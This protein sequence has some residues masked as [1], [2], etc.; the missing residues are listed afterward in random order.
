[1]WQNFL[2][3]SGIEPTLVA[4]GTFDA[5]TEG[6]TKRWQVAAGLK[7][8]G[9]VGPQSFSR[10]M[11]VGFNPLHDD[12]ADENGQNWPVQP[13]DIK[14]LISNESREALFGKFAYKPTGDVGEI[15]ITDK[16]EGQNI[17]KCHIPFNGG[18]DVRMNKK[19]IPQ[20]LALWKAWSDASLLNRVLTWDGGFVPR[21]VR[22]SRTNLSNHSW[23]TAFDIN[24]E[25]N[26]LGKQGALKGEKGCIR[27]LMVIAPQFGFFNGGWFKSRPDFM[28]F[29]VF[30]II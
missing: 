21:F 28:H 25:W 7:G 18:K 30:K 20:F 16:W 22:G 11:M 9:V 8:D 24:A 27:E 19:I 1:M 5:L 6:A 3:G 2:V 10:A 23:G 17:E 12:H 14:P 26:G 15:V 29:E 4:T 13:G